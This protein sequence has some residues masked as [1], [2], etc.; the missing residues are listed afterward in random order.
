MVLRTSNNDKTLDLVGN[1][2]RNCKALI[3]SSMSDSLYNSTMDKEA[4]F[5]GHWNYCSPITLGLWFM[6]IY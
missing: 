1:A 3:E 5:V 2:V 6:I 4:I